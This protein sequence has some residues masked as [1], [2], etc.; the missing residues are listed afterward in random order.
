M[1]S[2]DGTVT[3]EITDLLIDT[4]LGDH[5]QKRLRTDRRKRR[6]VNVFIHFYEVYARRQPMA[7][8]FK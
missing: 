3:Q 1:I 2:G 5:F 8:R 4:S 7:D 6:G